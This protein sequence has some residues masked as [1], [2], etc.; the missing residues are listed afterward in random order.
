MVAT[1]IVVIV[2]A[3]V[4]SIQY[5]V[6]TKTYTDKIFGVIGSVVATTENNLQ[7]NTILVDNVIGS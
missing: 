7:P 5:P 3:W 2:G 4:V 6:E 1:F